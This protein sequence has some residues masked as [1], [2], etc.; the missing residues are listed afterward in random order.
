MWHYTSSRFRFIYCKEKKGQYLF[1]LTCSMCQIYSQV[2]FAI[3]RTY[4]IIII[5][6]ISLPVKNRALCC[7]S[8][9]LNPFKRQHCFIRPSFMETN[10]KRLELSREFCINSF[11]VRLLNDTEPLATAQPG[12]VNAVLEKLQLMSLRMCPPQCVRFQTGSFSKVT[13]MELETQRD[14]NRAQVEVNPCVQSCSL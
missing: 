1:L 3:Y 2:N 11:T 7:I 5:F 13:K 9:W 8:F 4:V 12:D 6:S 14:Y 10:M